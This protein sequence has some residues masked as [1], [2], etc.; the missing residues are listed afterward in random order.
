M[1][2]LLIIALLAAIV[3]AVLLAMRRSGPRVTEIETRR[4]EVDEDG[5]A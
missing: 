2:S 1:K 5:D 3:V 4:E